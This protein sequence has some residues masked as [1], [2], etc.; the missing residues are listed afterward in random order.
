MAIEKFR[1]DNYVRRDSSSRSKRSIAAIKYV[2]RDS[3]SV[4]ES[5]SLSRSMELSKRIIAA[6]NYVSQ[7]RLVFDDDNW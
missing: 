2:S 1:Y 5:E 4:P 6:T 3:R 7:A